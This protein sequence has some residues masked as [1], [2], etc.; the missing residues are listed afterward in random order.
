MHP[1]AI[2]RFNCSQQYSMKDIA[3]ASKP[4]YP[5]VYLEQLTVFSGIRIHIFKNASIAFYYAILYK[6]KH[7]NSF[8]KFDCMS[9]H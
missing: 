1:F 3:I 4:V 9:I 8:V 7:R 2:H 6:K 5:E